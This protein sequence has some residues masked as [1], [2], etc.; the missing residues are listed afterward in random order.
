M[1]VGRQEGDWWDEKDMEQSFVGT[2]YVCV[3]WN[4]DRQDRLR[5]KDYDRILEL[6][7]QQATL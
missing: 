3:W 7:C 1:V 4:W 2:V 6:S 5:T